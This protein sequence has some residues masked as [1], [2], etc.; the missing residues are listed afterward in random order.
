MLACLQNSWRVQVQSVLNIVY[1]FLLLMPVYNI[2]M[3]RFF[4]FFLMLAFL[5]PWGSVAHA[6][7]TD[8]AEVIL[9]SA[10]QSFAPEQQQLA[11][12]LEFQLQ[13]GWKIYWRAPGAGGKPPALHWQENSD[14]ITGLE[15]Q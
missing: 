10:Q 3:V 4:R 6:V 8:Q 12:G 9:L 1:Q 7:K 11:F 14:K 2:V 5:M 13:P 15:I